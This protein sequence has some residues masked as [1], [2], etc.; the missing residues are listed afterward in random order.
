VAVVRRWVL[1]PKG[2]MLI[3]APGVCHAGGAYDSTSEHMVF[4]TRSGGDGKDGK[5]WMIGPSCLNVAAEL[6]ST[7]N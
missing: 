2:A 3:F 4:F 6:T 7:D 5:K 1:V